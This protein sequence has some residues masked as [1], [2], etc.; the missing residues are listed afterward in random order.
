MEILP[1]S[2]ALTTQNSYVPGDALKHE[3]TGQKSP[4]VL[5]KE[6]PMEPHTPLL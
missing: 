2:N 3:S 4:E 6:I 5:K 1:V